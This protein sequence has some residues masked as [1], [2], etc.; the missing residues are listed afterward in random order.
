MKILLLAPHPF[1][2]ER[3]TPIAVDL[4]VRTLAGL[5]HRIDVLTYHEGQDREYPDNVSI[6]RIKRPPFAQG[7]RP[8]FSFKKLISDLYMFPEAR[9][10]ERENRYDVIHAVE[11]SVFMAKRIG[12]EFK[13][14]YIFDMDSS[15]PEQIVEK[16]G[17]AKLLLPMMNHF[18]AGAV[19]S[20][21]AVVPVCQALAEKAKRQGAKRIVLLRDISLLG[22]SKDFGVDIKT[23]LGIKGPVVLYVGNLEK[24]QGID[25]LL[26]CFK[27]VRC[28]NDSVSLVIIG[29]KEADILRY[30]EKAGRL[31]LSG[32]VYLPGPRP[33]SQMRGLLESADILVSPRIKGG[34]TPMKIYS[35]MDSGRPIL[36]TRLETHTQVLDDDI[37]MLAEPEPAAFAGAMKLLLAD[38]ELR[39]RL[40]SACMRT[41]AERHSAEAFRKS[42]SEVYSAFGKGDS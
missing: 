30:R 9:R 23:E 26:E 13:T 4:L 8:G 5:G 33:V 36:A 24:Y 38:S 18:E 29:G 34:N 16:F 1:Y 12:R 32:A 19:K 37:A 31:G 14:P 22:D 27:I 41:A 21:A 15:M 28:E 7:I 25:L 40:G 39:A 3:G 35:Y 20:A 2:Q 11:E 42:V 6:R 10:M 17:W